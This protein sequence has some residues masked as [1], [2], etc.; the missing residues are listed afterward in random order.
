M[1]W[2]ALS[3]NTTVASGRGWKARASSLW[4]TQFMGLRNSM[5]SGL[6]A[7]PLLRLNDSCLLSAS[8][9]Y[10]FIKG[11]HS[12]FVVLGQSSSTESVGSDISNYACVFI[13]IYVAGVDA[14]ECDRFFIRNFAI[15]EYGNLRYFSFTWFARNFRLDL[16]FLSHDSVKWSIS[17]FEINFYALK[18]LFFRSKPAYWLALFAW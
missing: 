1:D 11:R 8:S 4:V 16:E 6:K 18:L 15:V 14:T 5:T 9:N 13:C 17:R 3:I 2:Y 10:L 12:F 7:R